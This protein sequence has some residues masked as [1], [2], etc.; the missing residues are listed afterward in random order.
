MDLAGIDAA[1][2]TSAAG[3][4]ADLN[5]LALGQRQ[6]E[7]GRAGLSRP[8]IGAVHADPL[9]G[10][11]ALKEVARCRHEP[12]FQGVTICWNSTAS[13]ST[14]RRSS[15][16]G[17]K[18][19]KLG[20]FVFVHLVLKPNQAQ[21]STPT[22]PRVASAAVFADHGDDPAAIRRVPPPSRPTVHMAHLSAGIAG[23]LARIRS[24]QDKT[25]WWTAGNPA[26]W[27]H[28]EA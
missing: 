11:A 3:M 24:F 14:I 6:G 25:F 2:L 16:S 17:T 20:L 26:P 7:K 12:G 9:G 4:C 23:M 5:N 22:T 28:A 19:E 10:V 27:R 13:G 21:A 18:G 15:C 8:L 1:W